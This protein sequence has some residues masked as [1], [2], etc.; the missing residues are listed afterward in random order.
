MQ[1]AVFT[2][3]VSMKSL[4]LVSHGGGQIK[5]ARGFQIH[6]ILPADYEMKIDAAT[7]APPPSLPSSALKSGKHMEYLHSYLFGERGARTFH[8]TYDV[9]SSSANATVLETISRD[10]PRHSSVLMRVALSLYETK[11]KNTWAKNKLLNNKARNK[12][13]EILLRIHRA[14]K[15]ESHH[16]EKLKEERRPKE[17]QAKKQARKKIAKSRRNTFH[18]AIRSEKYKLQRYQRKAQGKPEGNNW[19][20]LA[21]HGQDRINRMYADF[22][23]AN[24]K[25]AA[26][27]S[28]QA[29]D[30]ASSSTAASGTSLLAPSS[31]NDRDSTFD[32]VAAPTTTHSNSLEIDDVPIEKLLPLYDPRSVLRKLLVKQAGKAISHAQLKKKERRDITDDEA[33]VCLL[34]SKIL[35]PYI[36][37]A[38]GHHSYIGFQLPFMLLANDIFCAVGYGKFE[39][40]LCPTF[41]CGSLHVMRLDA[42]S[43]YTLCTKGDDPVD[44]FDFEGY[45]MPSVEAARAHK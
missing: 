33:R 41:S 40:N 23:R 42:I 18:N 45:H 2:L 36:P 35:L 3:M 24:K 16:Y 8:S 9:L 26:A 15:R 31:S 14:P 37:T 34:L 21:E 27:S 17:Q 22:K 44:V 5:K 32:A 13:L 30:P 29:L 6:D 1:L 25:E 7:S 4:Q 38:K 20:R 10:T 43:V 28:G 19:A 11:L 39:V 12:L